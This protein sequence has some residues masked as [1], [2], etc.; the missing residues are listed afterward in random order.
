MSVV[1]PAEST[2]STTTLNFN[3]L[4]EDATTRQDTC[5]RFVAGSGSTRAKQDKLVRHAQINRAA[6]IH[7]WNDVISSDSIEF[8][9]VKR[10][11]VRHLPIF[12]MF[13]KSNE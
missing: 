2:P 6:M 7:R 1:L 12:H 8:E 5:G 11:P 13:I 3:S 4:R 9:A 10:V